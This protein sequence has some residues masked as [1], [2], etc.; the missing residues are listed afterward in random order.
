MKG[1]IELKKQKHEKQGMPLTSQLWEEG[2]ISSSFLAVKIS[3][4]TKWHLAWPCLPVLEV[5]TSTT[6]HKIT[7]PSI[8]PH[9]SVTVS[10]KARQKT[11][12]TTHKSKINAQKPQ[13]TNQI[14][15]QSQSNTKGSK[16]NQSMHPRKNN[17]HHSM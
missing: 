1:I 8:H 2:T 3:I 13:I 12:W 6:C 9:A 10:S 5:E 11:H 14:L 15:K 17:M 4:P 16:Q 7:N